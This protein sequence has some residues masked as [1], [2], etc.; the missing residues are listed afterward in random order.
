MDGEAVNGA[1]VF[2]SLGVD[3]LLRTGAQY[4]YEQ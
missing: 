4:F 3:C 1:S 2:M